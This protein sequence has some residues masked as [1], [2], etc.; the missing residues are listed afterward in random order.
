MKVLCITEFAH[1]G[2]RLYYAGTV[3]DLKEKEAEA[4]IGL[5]K[6]KELGALS[7]FNPVDDDA[8]KFFNSKKTSESAKASDSK[9]T[10]ESKPVDDKK[11]TAKNQQTAPSSIE[12]V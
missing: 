7:F 6:K 11:N 4:L 2:V 8:I 12:T 5:D 3:Y 9:K 10:S 1:S